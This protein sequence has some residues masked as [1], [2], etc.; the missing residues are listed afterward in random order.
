MSL[1]EAT[2]TRISATIGSDRVVLFMKGTRDFPQ[3]GFSARV[4]QMLDRLVPDYTTVDVLADPAIRQGI[5]DFSRWPTIPQLYV[6]GEF[7][8]GCDIVSEMFQSGE[9]Q[10]LMREK[11]AQ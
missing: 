9:L 10:T 2:R 8:G 3:C 11:V 1:D 5:K 6:A 7:V 4:V